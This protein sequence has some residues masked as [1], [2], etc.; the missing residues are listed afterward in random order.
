[1]S[2]ILHADDDPQW[3]RNVSEQLKEIRIGNRKEVVEG[4]PRYSPREAESAIKGL[5]REIGKR[6]IDAVILD[7]MIGGGSIKE[8]KRWV[9]AVILLVKT[10]PREEIEKLSP[11]AL[12][13]KLPREARDDVDQ[14]CP[15]LPAGRLAARHGAKVVILTNVATFLPEPLVEK[16]LQHK[17]VM[18][19][20]GSSAYVVKTEEDWP[21]QLRGALGRLLS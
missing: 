15:I 17:C 18:A 12:W 8:A 1:M 6:K 16:T 9:D 10:L 3:Q 21:E 19:A 14:K 4:Y 13:K 2:L 5:D 11:E 20:S 7:L